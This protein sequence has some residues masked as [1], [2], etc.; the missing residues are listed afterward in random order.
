MLRQVDEMACHST[1]ATLKCPCHAV[2]NQD[3]EQVEVWCVYCLP[4]RG[5]AVE[6]ARRGIMNALAFFVHSSGFVLK[7][8]DLALGIVDVLQQ[9]MAGS[10]SVSSGSWCGRSCS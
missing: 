10:S 7:A 1:V 5:E 8:V 2:L 3:G 9:V 6:L 4:Q